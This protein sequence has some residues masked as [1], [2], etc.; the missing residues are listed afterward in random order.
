M[1][2]DSDK[3]VSLKT[4]DVPS[5]KV[6]QDELERIK[7]HILKGNSKKVDTPKLFT[8]T[9]K[10]G[11]RICPWGAYC[12]PPSLGLSGISLIDSISSEPAICQI[13]DVKTPSSTWSNVVK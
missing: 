7:T 11:M 3:V 2:P 5:P 6:E 8:Q 1:P 10:A 4:L 13:G 9:A 12:M